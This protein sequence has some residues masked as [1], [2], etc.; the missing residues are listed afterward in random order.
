MTDS[1]SGANEDLIG[2]WE[3]RS[4]DAALELA[5][6]SLMMVL[7]DGEL[8]YASPGDG[9]MMVANLRYRIEGEWLVTDQDSAPK[10][11]RTR[12]EVQSGGRLVLEY[13]RGKSVWERV[14][15]KV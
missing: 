3:L 12:F 9:A 15:P 13:G 4:A 2:V 1:G 11:D 7:P 14:S 8:R 5:P 10:Q 6:G